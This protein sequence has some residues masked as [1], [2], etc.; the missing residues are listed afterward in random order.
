MGYDLTYRKPWSKKQ[1]GPGRTHVSGAASFAFWRILYC[2]FDIIIGGLIN[3]QKDWVI[4]I[5]CRF[6]TIKFSGV[7]REVTL[8]DAIGGI[9]GFSKL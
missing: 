2:Y 8:R 3:S 1:S 9:D 5:Y 7:T 6:F 4:L